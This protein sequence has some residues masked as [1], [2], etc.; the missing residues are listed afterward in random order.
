MTAPDEPLHGAQ[1]CASVAELVAACQV[2]CLTLDSCSAPT[3]CITEPLTMCGA[4][5]SDLV[6]PR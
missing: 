1:L 3:L 2:L 4:P 6:P 5:D